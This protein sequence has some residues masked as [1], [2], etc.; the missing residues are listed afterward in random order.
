VTPEV[1]PLNLTPSP[2]SSH[3][4]ASASLEV[5]QVDRARNICHRFHAV[6]RQLRLRGE[7]RSTLAVED[8]ID[9]Q[10]LLHALLRLQFDD[11]GTEEWIPSYTN[12]TPR[13]TLFLDH[14]RLVIVVKK[15]RPGLSAKDLADQVR[16]DVERYR[17]RERC[18][19]LLCFI[20]DP[21]GRIGNPRGLECDLSTVS[22]HFSVDVLVAPK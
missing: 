2:Q 10:D 14:D 11:V 13:T 4:V 12:G 9:V 7:Y 17:Y 3:S 20:Y 6:A 18:T 5:D 21:E 1:P 19:T 16:I 8:E 15:S 22:D